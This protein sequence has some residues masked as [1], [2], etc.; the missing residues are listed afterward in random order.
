[1]GHAFHSCV[2]SIDEGSVDC[3]SKTRTPNKAATSVCSIIGQC[4]HVDRD[5]AASLQASERVGEDPRAPGFLDV[6]CCAHID[7]LYRCAHVLK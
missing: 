7:R 3:I 6:N 4:R 5:E 2:T 1:M